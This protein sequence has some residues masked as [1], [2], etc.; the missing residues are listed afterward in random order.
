[1]KKVFLVFILCGI[2][3]ISLAQ[4]GPGG[5]AI[6]YDYDAMGNRIKRS[7]Y[8]WA[9]GGGGGSLKS[10]GSNNQES[11]SNEILVYPNP[12]LTYVTI[13]TKNPVKSGRIILMDMMGKVI[14]Q[15]ISGEFQ[16][17]ISVSQLASGVYLIKYYNNANG[18]TYIKNLVID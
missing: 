14:L 17:L 2:S 10:I 1:M 11:T 3:G 5:C 18:Q 9:G 12:A 7:K 13:E 15:S 4:N 6:K 16:T 8:C